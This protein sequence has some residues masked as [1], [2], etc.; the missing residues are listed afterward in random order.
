MRDKENKLSIPKT[1]FHQTIIL[2]SYWP[3]ANG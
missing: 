3:S 2:S 1:Y